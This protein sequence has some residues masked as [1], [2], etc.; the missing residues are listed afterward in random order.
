MYD[1]ASGSE[2]PLEALIE[3]I[4]DKNARLDVQ[5]SESE[6]PLAELHEREK[7]SL[8]AL[9]ALRRRSKGGEPS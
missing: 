3:K 8:A 4:R 2:Q 7:L 9:R 1:Q 6:A 5:K